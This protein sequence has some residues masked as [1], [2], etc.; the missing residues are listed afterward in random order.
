MNE[1]NSKRER[2]VARE[3]C[4]FDTN[5]L[6][7]PFEFGLNPYDGVRDLIPGV[8]LVTL[9]ECVSELKGLRP[10]K[11][12]SILSLGVQNRLEVVNSEVNEVSV[13][14]RI[15]SF[16]SREKCLV[17]TQDALLRKKLLAKGLRIVLMR[18]KKT[19]V[20]MG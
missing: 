16:A 5:A 15:V 1:D 2:N 12:E 8:R 3:C 7:I 9:E 20:L 19:F 4:V 14:D 13:D 6:L 18:N 11:W 10:S 17:L